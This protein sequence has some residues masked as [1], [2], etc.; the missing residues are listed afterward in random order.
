MSNELILYPHN[1]M[2]F[3]KLLFFSLLIRDFYTFSLLLIA[4]IFN[5]MFTSRF[6]NYGRGWIILMIIVSLYCLIFFAISSLWNVLGLYFFK[7]WV[8][9]VKKYALALFLFFYMLSFCPFSE[10]TLSKEIPFSYF[11][12]LH[13]FSLGLYFYYFREMNRAIMHINDY[14]KT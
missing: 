5:L 13:L 6:Y 9:E 12:P 7:T 11:L 3:N 14:D 8:V 4:T 1:P 10:M 2:N